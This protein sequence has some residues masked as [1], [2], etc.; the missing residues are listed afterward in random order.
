MEES[1]NTIRQHAA[2]NTRARSA[3]AG[4]DGKCRRNLNRPA[5][6]K[7]RGVRV[8]RRGKSPPPGAQAPGHDKPHVVQGRTGSAGSPGPLSAQAGGR[9]RVLAALRASGAVR[10]S[11]LREMIAHDRI[12]LTATHSMKALARNGGRLRF[13][14]RFGFVCLFICIWL[15]RREDEEEEEAEGEE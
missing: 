4:R 12:R 7:A 14:P 1:P 5:G 2:E 13:F 10:A 9:F 15:V 11:G 6:R 3:Q 8:K